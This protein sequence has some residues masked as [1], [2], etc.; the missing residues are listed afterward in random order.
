MI[1][2]KSKIDLELTKD[3]KVATTMDT[4][5]HVMKNKDKEAAQKGGEFI[6]KIGS[7]LDCGEPICK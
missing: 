1:K 2:R 5:L 4:Y 7:P 6:S 3:F